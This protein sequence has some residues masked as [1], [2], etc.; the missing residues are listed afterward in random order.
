MAVGGPGTNYASWMQDLRAGGPQ[1][2]EATSSV[3]PLTAGV[4]A[5]AG[6]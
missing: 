4:Q 5:M 2:L 3:S 6:S 1:A